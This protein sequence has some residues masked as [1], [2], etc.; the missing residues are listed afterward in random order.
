MRVNDYFVVAKKIELP[1]KKETGVYIP[2]R[3]REKTNRAEV[4][5]VAENM[6]D[7]VKE[8]EVV[9]FNPLRGVAVEE[10]NAIVL[11]KNDI[12]FVE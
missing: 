1:E 2:S 10:Y 3:S 8:K 5:A 6:K 11:H 9:V 7:F 12:Y 4:I